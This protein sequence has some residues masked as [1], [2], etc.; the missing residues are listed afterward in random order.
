MNQ[1]LITLIPKG[2]NPSRITQFHPIAFCNVVYK[3]V[4]KI[5]SSR[6]KNILPTIIGLHQSS[7]IQGRSTTDNIIVLQE[8]IHSMSHLHGKRGFMIIK[9]DLEKAYDRLEWSFIH[10]TLELLNFPPSM[11]E[12]IN[13][14]ISSAIMS[15][16]W[17]GNA[18]SSFSSSRGL[19]Q[20]DPI[21]PY[22]FVLSLE[23]LSHRIL[24][25]VNNDDWILMTFGR[26]LGPKLSHFFLLMI[27]F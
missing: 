14:C 19:R 18:S 7:F 11:R 6:I 10:D 13:V 5:I 4:T 15:I 12:L 20:G 25:A 9:L 2:G 24:D 8:T 22:M 17:N 27:L 16:N 3:I 23:R 1:T 21:P 26:R